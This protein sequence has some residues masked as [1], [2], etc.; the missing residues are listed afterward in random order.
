MRGKSER[1]TLRFRM[2]DRVRLKS[3]GP[4][5]AE[6]QVVAYSYGKETFDLM[7]CNPRAPQQFRNG[8]N[9]DE[10]ELIAPAPERN[11]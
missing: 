11:E 6:W 1:G 7:A 3:D 4:D 9:A 8:M 2:G 5:G 10:L